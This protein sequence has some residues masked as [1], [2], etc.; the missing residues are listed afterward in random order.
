MLIPFRQITIRTHLPPADVAIAISGL[1]DGPPSWWSIFAKERPGYRL[2]GIADLKRVKL[3]V[4]GKP[5][6]GIAYMPVASGTLS[7]SGGE[8][9]VA[10]K[11]YPRP[12]EFAFTMFWASGDT[13]NR[14]LRDT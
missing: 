8:T 10:L 13:Q 4:L 7:G 6:H 1:L 14:P 9:V 3:R 11:F 2:R 12:I 5:W